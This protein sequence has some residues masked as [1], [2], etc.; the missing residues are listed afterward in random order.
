MTDSWKSSITDFSPSE[1]NTFRFYVFYTFIF[2]IFLISGPFIFN[3]NWIGSSDF[4]SCTE[5]SSS[6]IAY[7]SAIVCK[8]G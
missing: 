2:A 6:L 1:V 5:I 4:H 7:L 8:I 3:N